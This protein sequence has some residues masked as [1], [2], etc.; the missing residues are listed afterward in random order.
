MRK[1]IHAWHISPLTP[2]SEYSTAASLSP[3]QGKAG[4]LICPLPCDMWDVASFTLCRHSLLHS[5][6]GMPKPEVPEV[7]HP[8]ATCGMASPG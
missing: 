1:T 2:I 4:A 3:M 5:Y 7:P 8:Q 6:K